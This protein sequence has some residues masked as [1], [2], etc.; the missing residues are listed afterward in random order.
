MAEF[1]FKET[2]TEG[3]WKEDEHSINNAFM[4]LI[5]H[6]C[7]INNIK[8][9]EIS[10]VFT[11]N[12]FRI[13]K[14]GNKIIKLFFPNQFGNDCSEYYYAELS[15][16]SQAE[17]AG[18]NAPEII[19]TGIIHDR[20]NFYYIVMSYIDGVNAKEALPNYTDSE[21][22]E[23][24]EKFKIITDK[25]SLIKDLSKTPRFDQPERIGNNMWGN[26]W[27]DF[28][29]LFRENRQKYLSKQNLREI[30][31]NHGDTNLNNI[32]IDKSSK[33]FLIDFADSAAAPYLYDLPT[34]IYSVF[35]CEP[36]MMKTYFGN[37]KNEEFYEKVMI[38]LL[39]Y[40]FGAYFIN[41]IAKAVNIKMGNISDMEMLKDVV[42][43]S[44]DRGDIR[45]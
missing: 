13:G 14:G 17:K 39:I 18:I 3:S 2:L 41:S 40:W 29:E 26:N 22:I 7:G 36:L 44:I 10:R 4:P 12:V 27:G 25:F 32:I 8:F 11:L 43:K 16:L 15:A 9:E 20:Y 45:F 37:Y 42:V 21:K 35:A 33:I 28:T 23:F 5:T 34:I 31:F 19:C 24:C 38:S 6:I 1:I 30:V